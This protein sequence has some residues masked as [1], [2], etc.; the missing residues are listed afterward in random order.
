MKG[1]AGLTQWRRV[2]NLSLNASKTKDLI[3]A[4]AR[5]RQSSYATLEIGRASVETVSSFKY[6]GVHTTNERVYT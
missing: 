3:V 6:L 4:C 5:M 2:S 1:E